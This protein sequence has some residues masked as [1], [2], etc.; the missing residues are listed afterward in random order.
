MH[1]NIHS[2]QLH[3]EDVRII[4]HLLE[5][6]FDIIAISESRLQK[7]LHPKVDISLTGYQNP[8]NTLTEANKGGVLIHAKS[9]LNFKLRN[10]L[11][12]Y[13]SKELESTFIETINPIDANSIVGV[14]Y[15]HPC[16]DPTLFNDD[17]LNP[18]YQD[19]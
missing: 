16:M 15:R 12:I 6:E 2:I 9:N 8:V 1:L 10:D 19:F 5:F 4:L 13:K 11:N 18:F 14:I 17:F 7:G 3:I